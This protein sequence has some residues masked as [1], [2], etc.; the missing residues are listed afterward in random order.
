MSLANF[1]TYQLAV[2]LHRLILVLRV[3]TY[4]RDQ[5]LRSSSSVALNIAESSGKLTPADKRRYFSIA[6]GSLRETSAALDLLGNPSPQIA[7]LVD[8][9]GALLWRLCHPRSS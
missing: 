4:L 2:E 1:R 6:L 3:P 9:L 7:N 8:Q 5:I